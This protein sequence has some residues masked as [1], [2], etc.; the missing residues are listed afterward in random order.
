MAAGSPSSA[1]LR[2]AALLR[3]S[4]C[5]RVADLNGYRGI[6]WWP[7]GKSLLVR[8]VPGIGGALVRLFLDDGRKTVFTTPTDKQAEG[9]PIF[10]PDG[11]HVAFV[12]YRPGGADACWIA[13]SGGAIHCVAKAK[14]IQ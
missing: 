10:S 7:D 4:S 11:R 5:P 13:S 9:L 2:P 8:D 1:N 14:S 3:C 6:A 12:H